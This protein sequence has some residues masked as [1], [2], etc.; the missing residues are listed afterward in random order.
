MCD[1]NYILENFFGV[2]EDSANDIMTSQLTSVTSF[3]VHA[4]EVQ[5]TAL[6]RKVSNN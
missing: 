4:K 3:L 6:R 1:L 2:E 5:A